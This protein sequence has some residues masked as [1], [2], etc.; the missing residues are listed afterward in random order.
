[1]DKGVKIGIMNFG[2]L[3]FFTARVIRIAAEAIVAVN[4]S[5]NGT[6]C[7]P[8]IRIMTARASSWIGSCSPRA[9]SAGA[10]PEAEVEE[11]EKVDGR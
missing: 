3:L 6:G 4:K 10:I 11:K 5:T 7:W 9:A 1:M 8:T 2:L